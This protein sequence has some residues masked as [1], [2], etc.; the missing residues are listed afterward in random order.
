MYGTPVKWKEG[1]DATDKTWLV[2]ITGGEPSIYPGFVELCE[3]LT[4]KHYL[5]INSNLTH[6]CIKD[7][8]ERINPERIHFINAALH[9]EER[10]KRG[11]FNLFIERV[12]ELKE[13][14]FNVLLSQLMTPYVVSNYHEITEQLGAH[15]LFAIPKVIRGTHGGKHYPASYSAEKKRLI[16]K[17]LME[18]TENYETVLN[19]MD[20]R[21]TINLF[22]DHSFLDGIID[23]RGRLCSAGKNFVSIVPN[24]TVFRC[25]SPILGNILFKD[26]RLLD[27]PKICDMWYCPYFCEKYSVKDKKHADRPALNNTKPRLLPSNLTDLKRE[28]Y[29]LMR[30]DGCME[31]VKRIASK[32]KNKITAE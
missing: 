1:F 23:Y 29:Y 28:M 6:H 27:S 22:S 15:G 25:G 13:A 17:Y 9:I 26:V 4:Q 20:E 24:G 30:T 16:N 5:A 19:N 31:V 18:A 3:Q 8:I 14:K 11:L 32:V 21:P 10:Q 2:H 7:F 12:Y